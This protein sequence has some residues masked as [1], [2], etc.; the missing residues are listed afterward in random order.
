MRSIYFLTK[1]ERT[2]RKKSL[3]LEV[4]MV[5]AIYS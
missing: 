5:F 1:K 3:N 4:F 2:K